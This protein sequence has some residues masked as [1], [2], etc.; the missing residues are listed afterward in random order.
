LPETFLNNDDVSTVFTGWADVS[1]PRWLAQGSPQGIC[2]GEPEEVDVKGLPYSRRQ[3]LMFQD[4]YSPEDLGM[5]TCGRGCV[6]RCTFCSAGSMLRHRTVVRTEDSIRRE[7]IELIGEWNVSTVN[8]ADPSFTCRP[9]LYKPVAT[10]FKDFHIPW[11]CTGRW[12]TITKDLIDHFVECGCNSIGVGLESGSDKILRQMRKGAT[13]KI[14]REQAKILNDLGLKWQLFCIVGFPDETEEDMMQ[15]RDL[16]MEIEPSLI[17]LNSMTPLPG[18][19]VYGQIPDM[20][21]EFASALNQHF[22]NYCFSRHMDLERFRSIF[23]EMMET[24]DTYNR[25]KR[26]GLRD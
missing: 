3:A 10:L 13:R 2:H 5:L 7:L 23:S 22:P 9:A 19:E 1:F 20:T 25:A 15:T 4:N 18:T 14:I 21:P 17:S 6:G 26:G 12:A 24:F 11:R 16:A 8:A